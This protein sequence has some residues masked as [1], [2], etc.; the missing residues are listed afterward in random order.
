[1]D[2][3]IGW[4]TKAARRGARVAHAWLV[5]AKDPGVEVTACG[6]QGERGAEFSPAMKGHRQCGRCAERMARLGILLALLFVAPAWAD[7]PRYTNEPGG[8]IT[9]HQS[10]RPNRALL[11]AIGRGYARLHWIVAESEASRSWFRFAAQWDTA[12]VWR[13]GW[14]FVATLRDGRVI[15]ATDVY[16]QTPGA[17]GIPIRLGMDSRLV[18][19]NTLERRRWKAYTVVPVFV[20]FPEVGLD[21][22]DVAGVQVRKRTARAAASAGAEGSGR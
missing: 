16:V 11:D 19:P 9:L 5:S 1:M 18:D 2:R 4:F 21:M 14:T 17:S 3:L 22:G 13:E 12:F 7:P 6:K 15:E 8:R 10:E 20:A